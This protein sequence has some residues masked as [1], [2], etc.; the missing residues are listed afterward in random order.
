MQL[1]GEAEAFEVE[2]EGVWECKAC[3][4]RKGDGSL[5]EAET[6][7]KKK[8]NRFVPLSLSDLIQSFQS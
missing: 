5:G 7:V 6:M 4:E 1:R 8:R 3:L 2:W